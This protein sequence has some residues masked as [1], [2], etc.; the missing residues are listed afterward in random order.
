MKKRLSVIAP[1]FKYVFIDF[2]QYQ[3]TSLLT[4]NNYLTATTTSLVYVPLIVQTWTVDTQGTLTITEILVSLA[5][6]NA[7][8]GKSKLQISKDGGMSFIDI[9]GDIGAGVLSTGGVGQWIT[10]VE[11]GNDKLQIRLLG[12]STN[13]LAANILIN[14]I[15]TYGVI[16]I[17]K[18]LV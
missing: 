11:T 18:T 15:N 16:T 8:N 17:F 12:M 6:N 1:T 13:G 14:N 2:S 9:T 3:G 10:D 7:V 5:T 4:S